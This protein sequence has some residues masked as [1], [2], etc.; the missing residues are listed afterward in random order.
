MTTL[1]ASI[2]ARFGSDY[3]YGVAVLIFATFAWSS[4][5][6]FT[7]IIPHDAFTQLTWRGM[8]GGATALLAVVL[9]HGRGTWAIYRSFG[10][11][12]WLFSLVNTLGMITYISALK[13][14]SVAHVTIIVATMP[15]FTT[16]AAWA[17]L[18]EKPGGASIIASL[19]AAGGVT[20]T[21]V[22][23][24]AEGTFAGDFVAMLMTATMI[25]SILVQ[26]SGQPVDPVAS[27]AVSGF[28]CTLICLPFGNP[29][30]VTTSDVLWLILFGAS[31]TGLGLILFFVGARYVPARVSALISALDAPLSPLWIWVVFGTVPLPATILGGIV[32]ILAVVGAV[33]WPMRR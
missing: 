10:R 19:V 14:T 9:T 20:I 28:L 25:V 24:A 3:H 31:N 11:S 22:A 18:R 32:V 7:R 29:T 26:R 6:L 12:G 5:G 21:V 13:L 1:A 33:L 27:A 8:F 4:T 15:L 30:A 2:R 16:L 23:G 17:V